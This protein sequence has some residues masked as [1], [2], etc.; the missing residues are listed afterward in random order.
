MMNIEE[1]AVTLSLIARK[2]HHKGLR[3]FIVNADGVPEEVKRWA[4]DVIEQFFN[5]KAENPEAPPYL[6]PRVDRQQVA[7]LEQAIG[8]ID[9]IARRALFEKK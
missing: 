8:E 2:E 1:L 3:D 5:P 7:R 6:G 9:Q 4:L